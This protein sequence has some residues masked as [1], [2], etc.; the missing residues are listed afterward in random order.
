MSKDKALPKGLRNEEVK[1][2]QIKRPP[3]P[4]I[5]MQDLVGDAVKDSAGTTSFKVSLPD[6]TIVYH[7]VFDN[8]LNEAF[9]IHVQETM[10][11]CKRKGFYDGYNASLAQLKETL[12]RK[13]TATKKLKAKKDDPTTTKENQKALERSNVLAKLDV[14]V[15]F[16]SSY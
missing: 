9:V 11:F 3:V 7:A 5:P 12:I 10:D 1:R 4:Y 2:G 16:P 13:S 6:G 8:G 14:F 15:C